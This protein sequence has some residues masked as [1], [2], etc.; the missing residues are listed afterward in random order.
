VVRVRDTVVTL[1][2][3]NRATL[4][5]QLLLERSTMGIADALEHLVGLQAQTANTW[6][7]G[8]WSRLE[9]FDPCAL[10]RLIEQRQAVRVALMRSTIHLVTTRDALAMRSLV[11]P[12]VERPMTGP[13]RRELKTTHAPAIAALGSELLS[14]RPLTNIELGKLLAARWPDADPS[15][16]VMAVRVTVPLA[17][18]PPRG[19]W[20]QSGAARHA[21]LESWVGR[22]LGPAMPVEVLVRRYLSA[23][24]PAA[25]ADAQAWS[26]LTRLREVFERLRPELV[27]FRDE[28]GRELF[29][30]PNASRPDP[31]TPAPVRFLY[32]YDNLM[33][34]HA[35]RSRFIPHE[36]QARVLTSI[37]NYSYGSLLVDGFARGVWRIERSGRTATLKVNLLDSITTPEKTSIAE[38]GHR[39]LEFW[40]ADA[41]SRELSMSDSG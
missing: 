11:Q 17:Q 10:S 21:P 30:M 20:G 25:P 28:N 9:G 27:T 23:F 35:D 34:G 33:L 36:Q 16:L 19:L 38:E 41:A 7:T 13:A 12:A 29:D 22:P 3:L 31:G 40:A 37:G 39:L 8:L 18:V 5:R 24:G 1:R 14:E 15:D 4:A 32:D 2:A 26:G 6:Y